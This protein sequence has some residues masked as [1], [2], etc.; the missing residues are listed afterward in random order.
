MGD[1]HRRR[2]LLLYPVLSTGVTVLNAISMLMANKVKE[3]QI[4]LIT[5]F[6]REKCK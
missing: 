5:L 1:I 4:Y 3:D 2:V 6:A